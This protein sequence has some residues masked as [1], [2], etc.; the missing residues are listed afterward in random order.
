MTPERTEELRQ[1]LDEI[2]SDPSL[3]G[4]APTPLRRALDVAYELLP[5]RREPDPPELSAD[6]PSWW[7]LP[8]NR[9]PG[10]KWMLRLFRFSHL[11]SSDTREL[12]E[13]FA[14]LA[15]TIAG[16]PQNPDTTA[17]LRHL[18]EA[19]DCA[20]TALLLGLEDA[21]QAEQEAP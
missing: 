10:V 5:K 20:V 19:K 18:R 7:V 16:L 15:H 4:M 13:R 1:I 8:E 2:A 6:A 12:S 9:H 11:P 14:H 17:S 3:I 21:A